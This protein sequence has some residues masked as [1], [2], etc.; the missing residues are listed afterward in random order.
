MGQHQ[1]QDP[2]NSE[3]IRY[4][5]T[6]VLTAG[7]C[8]M[9]KETTGPKTEIGKH[10]DSDSPSTAGKSIMKQGESYMSQFKAGGYIM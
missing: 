7:K 10:L 4:E 1:K 6:L 2:F 3:R 9:E 8:Q 5:E